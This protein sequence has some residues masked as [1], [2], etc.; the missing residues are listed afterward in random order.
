MVGALQV[1]PALKRARCGEQELVVV[2]HAGHA[3]AAHEHIAIGALAHEPFVLVPA[4][5]FFAAAIE[6]V[7]RRAGFVPRVRAR[8]ASLS[9]LCALVRARLAVTILPA[10]SVL[11]GDRTLKEVRFEAPAP[12]RPVNLIWR[13]D[14]RPTPALRAFIDI[15]REL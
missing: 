12:R 1:D 7:C 5:T 9:G 14:V 8:I 13:A 15:G 3:L 6:E 4:G 11:P 10:G 2:V